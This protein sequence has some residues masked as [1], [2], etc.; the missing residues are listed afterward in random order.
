[1]FNEKRNFV[2]NFDFEGFYILYVKNSTM[3]VRKFDNS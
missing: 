3:W 1:M 2:F